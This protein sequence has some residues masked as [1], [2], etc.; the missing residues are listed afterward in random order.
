MLNSRSILYMEQGVGKSFSIGEISG[1][2]NDLT[3]K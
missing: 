2:Y 1:Y 3:K